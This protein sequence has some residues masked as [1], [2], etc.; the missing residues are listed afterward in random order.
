MLGDCVAERA[1]V[2][3]MRSGSLAV[4]QETPMRW[5]ESQVGAVGL[6]VSSF[7]QKSPDHDTMRKISNVAV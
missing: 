5:R 1:V 7:T 2:G 6:A 4:E 3:V